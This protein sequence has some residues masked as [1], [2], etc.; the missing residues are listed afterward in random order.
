MIISHKYKII[1]IKCGKVA[2]TSVEMA[3]RPHLGEHDVITPVA[4]KDELFAQKN[5]IPASRNF[6][7]SMHYDDRVRNGSSRG[8]FYEHAWAYEIKGLISPEVWS[9][10]FKFA[11]VR[12]PREKSLSTYYHNRNGIRWPKHRNALNTVQSLLPLSMPLPLAHPSIA[13][14]VSLERWLQEDRLHTFCDNWCRYTVN[15]ELIIDRVYAFSELNTLVEDLEN[16]IDSDIKLPRLK[17]DFR[18]DRNLTSLE[19]DLLDKLL[20]NHTY[21][22]EF[23]LISKKSM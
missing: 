5:G 7:N 13:K 19:L 4:A 16:I 1:F 11:I 10:Y 22:K 15:D 21:Q 6:K 23:K 9:T 17:A 8:V 2:G 3:L 14:F 12:D 20:D 18:E